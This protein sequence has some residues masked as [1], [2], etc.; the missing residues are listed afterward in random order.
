MLNSSMINRWLLS[1]NAK[2]IGILYII[3]GA[4]SGLVGSALSFIIRLELSGGGPIYFI[5]NYHDY[6]TVIT[7]HGIVM[8]FFLVMPVLI[9]GFGKK[10]AVKTVMSCY[11]ST[12]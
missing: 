1:T 3:F 8:V 4:F 10:I 12:I 11:Y 5:G 6:N 9:G 7:G 2:D